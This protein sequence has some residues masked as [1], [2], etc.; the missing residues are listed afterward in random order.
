MMKVTKRKHFLSIN[1]K[2]Y[3]LSQIPILNCGSAVC[4]QC[5]ATSNSFNTLFNL[6]YI[7]SRYHFIYFVSIY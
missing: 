7:Y 4:D 1:F 2:L 3:F 6:V 5:T